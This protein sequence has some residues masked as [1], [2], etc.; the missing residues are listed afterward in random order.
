MGHPFGHDSAGG[1][2]LHSNILLEMCEHDPLPSFKLMFAELACACAAM[3]QAVKA[4]GTT[5]VNV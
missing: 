2:L 3:G 4:A 5:K 1:Q